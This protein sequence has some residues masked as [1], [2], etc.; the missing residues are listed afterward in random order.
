MV[1]MATPAYL[2]WSENAITF[3]HSDHPDQIL[4]SRSYLL[5]VN[6]IIAK[7]CL[8]K[9]LMDRGSGL[10][11]LYTETLSLMVINK[12]WLRNDAS[13]FHGVVPGHR[14]HHLG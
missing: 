2:K 14:A 9:V 5:I 7:T 4:N 10:N 6:P 12:Y 3:D 11:I 8:T 1:S 13:P